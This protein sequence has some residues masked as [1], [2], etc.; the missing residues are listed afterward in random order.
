MIAEKNSGKG[1]FERVEPV[2]VP[3][4][5]SSQES[6]WYCVLLL[7]CIYLITFIRG[8]LFQSVIGREFA[9]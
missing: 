9:Q 5:I 1:I 6:E 7:P 2:N 4:W 8:N 3:S